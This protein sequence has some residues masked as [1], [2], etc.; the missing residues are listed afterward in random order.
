MS[1]NMDSILSSPEAAARR[2]IMEE[3]TCIELPVR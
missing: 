3:I 2:R 1:A